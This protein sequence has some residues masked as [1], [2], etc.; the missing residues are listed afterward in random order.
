MAALCADAHVQIRPAC[1]NLYK[2]AE[3]DAEFVR[4]LITGAAVGSSAINNINRR[5]LGPNLAPVVDG[6]S[7]RQ[8]FLRSYTFSK[9]ET[10]PEKT[11]KCFGKV[12]ERAADLPCIR[13]PMNHC[14]ERSSGFSMLSP[15]EGYKTKKV[16]KKRK[17]RSVL[18]CIFHRLLSCMSSF[19]VAEGNSVVHAL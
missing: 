6:Y 9:K 2:S 8:K 17:G 14:G 3:S 18:W 4:S 12:K 13:S 15:G 5:R 16:P 7:C 19:D 1:A 10:V 11:A